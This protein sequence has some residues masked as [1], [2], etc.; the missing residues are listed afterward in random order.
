MT[1][2]TLESLKK[3]NRELKELLEKL[4]KNNE[5]KNSSDIPPNKQVRVT[6]VYNGMLNLKEYDNQ[7]VKYKFDKIGDS[8]TIPYSSLSNIVSWKPSLAYNGY[9]YIEDKDVVSSLEL[10]DYYENMLSFKDMKSICE[11]SDEKL[12]KILPKISDAQKKSILYVLLD[13]LHNKKVSDLNKVRKIGDLIGID[14]MG[15]YNGEYE[16]YYNN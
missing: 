14:I 2:T 5:S 16:K 12:D 1:N 6:S 4:L 13:D 15:K 3:E 9:Y 10:G 8:K 7:S 11:F